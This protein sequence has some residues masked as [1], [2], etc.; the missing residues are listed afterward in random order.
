MN[1][2]IRIRTKEQAEV[3]AGYQEKMCVLCPLRTGRKII[4]E[5]K[6]KGVSVF[7]DLPFVLRENVKDQILAD[8]EAADWADGFVVKN[9]DE[10]GLLDS[11]GRREN[12]IGDSFLYA[13]NS[14]AMAFYLEHF[15]DMRFITPD[16]LTDDELKRLPENVIYR[17]YGR[18]RVMLTAQSLSGNYGIKDGVNLESAMHDRIISLDEDY[19]FSA[20]YTADPVSMIDKDV[21]WENVMADLTTENAE[22]TA[23][24]LEALMA[25]GEAPSGIIRGHH[26]KGID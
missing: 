19:G 12:V 7:A 4:N 18:A 24:V 14:E 10:L 9:I 16:E 25:G 6:R 23:A 1:Y 11:I 2:Y 22:E 26:F 17:I 15:P 8:M 20:I 5:L 13:Y 3:L 21:P